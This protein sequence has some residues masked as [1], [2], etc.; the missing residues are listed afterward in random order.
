M[1]Y[2]QP[3]YARLLPLAPTVA[4]QASACLMQDDGDPSSWPINYGVS[5][6][7]NPFDH[8]ESVEPTSIAPLNIPA[9][10]VS[11]GQTHVAAYYGKRARRQ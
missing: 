8:G 1:G 5:D 2:A 9:I 4:G 11:V 7:L 10:D 3:A 6:M